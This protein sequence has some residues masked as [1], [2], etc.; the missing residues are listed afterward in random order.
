MRGAPTPAAPSAISS[1]FLLSFRGQFM[2]M[3]YQVLEPLPQELV[4]LFLRLEVHF[5]RLG[6]DHPE[7]KLILKGQRLDHLHRRH[8][9][10]LHVTSEGNGQAP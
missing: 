10:Y 4:P 6:V 1:R 8:Y 5:P 7:A 3:E 2:P 9:L